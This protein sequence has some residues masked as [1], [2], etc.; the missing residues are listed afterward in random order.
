MTIDSIASIT[1]NIEEVLSKKDVVS[2]ADDK[3]NGMDDKK[4]FE[5]IFE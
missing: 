1:N 5:E 4:N 3:F 2:K